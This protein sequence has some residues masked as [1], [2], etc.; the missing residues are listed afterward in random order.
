ML[1]RKP[2]RSTA[3]ATTNA[4]DSGALVPANKNAN[5]VVDFGVW[6]PQQRPPLAYYKRTWMHTKE[7]TNSRS[8]SRG[9]SYGSYF[10]EHKSHTGKISKFHHS[11]AGKKR[12][13]MG[14]V[15]VG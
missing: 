10:Y 3:V 15:D 11:L 2:K 7:N 5:L 8:E 4:N 12:D 9:G 1:A 13:A 6:N 14:G